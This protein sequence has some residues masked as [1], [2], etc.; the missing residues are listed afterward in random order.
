MRSIAEARALYEALGLRGRG[1]RGGAAGGRAGGAHPLRR[2]PHR[3][4]RADRRRLA[5]GQVP[6]A[7]RPGH[8]P[9]VP[10]RATTCA[11]PTSGCARPGVTL[12]RAEPTPGAGGCWVQFVHPQERRRRAARDLGVPRKGESHEARSD[13][14]PAPDQPDREV[15]GRARSA[16]AGGRHP[17]R[18]QH[19]AASTTG[20]AQA[21]R[22]EARA[23]S[24]WSPCSCRSSASSACSS[25]KQVGEVESYRQR[26]QRR[27]GAQR[28]ELPWD[29]GGGV[30]RGRGS[31]VVG[32]PETGGHGG[33]PLRELLLELHV[34]HEERR[35]FHAVVGQLGRQL[36]SER[37]TG[38][39]ARAPSSSSGA[40]SPLRRTPRWRCSSSTAA[41]ASSARKIAASELV[42]ISTSGRSWA[43]PR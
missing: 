26:F 35:G 28:R 5:G 21:A 18:H 8:A 14:H 40:R 43:V 6:G 3:A 16:A 27:V 20:C 36:G 24:G 42:V 9:P 2:E 11:P 30:G 22:R 19:R 34:S 15:L 1:D 13:G 38:R 23:A 32:R 7:A 41:A 39:R 29:A 4:A 25:T 10:A 31:A 33:P 17:A 12:L 37:R